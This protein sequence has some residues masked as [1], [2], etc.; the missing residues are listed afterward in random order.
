VPRDVPSS[1]Q[2]DARQ[3]AAPAASADAVPADEHRAFRVAPA[4]SA[5]SV[6]VVRE[7]V[8]VLPACSASSDA[9][10]ADTPVA[11]HLLDQAAL[12]AL[13]DVRQQVAVSR[14]SAE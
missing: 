14:P 12:T 8:A 2:R 10:A 13:Q 4:R 11:A 7:V 5:V 3:V 9:A 1:A 6:P